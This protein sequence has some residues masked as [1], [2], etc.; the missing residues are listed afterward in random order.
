M[1]R[2]LWLML[3]VTTAMPMT[4]SD[5]P[6]Q[7]LKLVEIT[8]EIDDNAIVICNIAPANSAPPLPSRH[9]NVARR[10]DLEIWRIAKPTMQ[11]PTL[12]GA[13]SALMVGDVL[14]RRLINTFHASIAVVPF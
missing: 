11:S 7:P 13:L 12:G 5:V 9:F 6:Q 1:K 10:K 8:L 4:L 3:V 14:R 2:C